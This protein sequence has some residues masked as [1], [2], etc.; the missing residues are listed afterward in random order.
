MWGELY[1]PQINDQSPHNPHFY[2][3]FN[4]RPFSKIP[5]A[6][7]YGILTKN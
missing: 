7:I 1:V 5:K 6:N 3:N 4:E 2:E